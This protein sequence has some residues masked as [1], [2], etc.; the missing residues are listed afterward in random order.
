[1]SKLIYGV[2]TNSKG[3]YKAFAD[4]KKTKVYVAWYNML[5]R[6]YCPKALVKHPTYIDCSVSD[7][8]LEFQDFASWYENH[9]YSSYEYE[10]DKDL[11]IPNNKIYAPDKCVFVPQQLNKL[12]TDSGAAR[13]EYKQGV[14]FRKDTNKFQSYISISGKQKKLGCFDN[15][16]DAYNAYKEAKEAHVK[17]M[18]NLWRD[19]IEA[20]VHHAL[21]T[22][23]LDS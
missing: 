7:E 18:A 2:G 9:K 1:M 19:K 10:L 13:G 8:W 11:L 21:I 14:S 22:W 5:E 6:V 17:Y 15:E 12:L 16:I 23:Q 3:T 4:G 20:P